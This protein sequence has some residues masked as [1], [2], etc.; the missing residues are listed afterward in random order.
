M[1]L[2]SAQSLVAEA[3]KNPDAFSDPEKADAVAAA[4]AVMDRQKQ[5]SPPSGDIG[6]SISAAR[7]GLPAPGAGGT[8]SA[9]T[10]AQQPPATKAPASVMQNL[11]PRPGY[12]RVSMPDGTTTEIPYSWSPRK[13]EITRMAMKVQDLGRDLTPEEEKRFYQIVL[14]EPTVLEDPRVEATKSLISAK[15]GTS[16]K[17]K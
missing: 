15:Y 10:P 1:T 11:P 3:T 16:M 17:W 2:E 14:Y 13:L 6:G 7:Q 5:P 9:S 12:Q 4:L 8:Q